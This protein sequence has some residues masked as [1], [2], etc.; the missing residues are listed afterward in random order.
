MP[1]WHVFFILSSGNEDLSKITE[2]AL[3]SLWVDFAFLIVFFSCPLSFYLLSI[4]QW[5]V[6]WIIKCIQVLLSVFMEE[7]ELR[8]KTMSY[9]CWVFL[10]SFLKFTVLRFYSFEIRDFV[11]L[12]LYYAYRFSGHIFFKIT[13]YMI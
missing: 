2:F 9:K 4:Q 10:L 6:L 1:Y 13:Y 5:L 3:V 11:I 8:A 7:K 12:S